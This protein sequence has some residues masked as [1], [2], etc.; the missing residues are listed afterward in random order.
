MAPPG[1]LQ[2]AVEIV[3]KLFGAAGF[4]GK[5]FAFSPADFSLERILVQSLKNLL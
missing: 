4:V 3:Q 5:A 1:F 2:K